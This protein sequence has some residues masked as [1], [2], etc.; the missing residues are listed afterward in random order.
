MDA[1]EA[2]FQRLLFIDAFFDGY[3]VPSAFYG[4]PSTELRLMR[5]GARAGEEYSRANP[6]SAVA[7]YA[8][9][10]YT[11]VTVKGMWTTEFES[12]RFVPAEGYPG[13]SWWLEPLP[14]L[15]RKLPEGFVP[16]EGLTVQIS[17]YV[18]G[19]GRREHL[20][21]YHRQIYVRELNVLESAQQSVAADRREDA[22]PA[23]R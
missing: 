14:E 5:A 6:D 21:V 20:G 19:P 13:E 18:S 9:F 1:C 7:T 15:A 10:G 23:E 8:S 3:R 11:A 2:K 22:A 16:E 4:D 17:G 12:S